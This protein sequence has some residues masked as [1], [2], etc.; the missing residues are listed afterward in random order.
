VPAFLAA[1]ALASICLPAAARVP[2]AS[3]AVPTSAES[4]LLKFAEAIA[5][6]Q[7]GRWK[8]SYELLKATVAS[9]GFAEM[10]EDQQSAG[11]YLLGSVALELEEPKVALEALRNATRWKLAAGDVWYARL[12]AAGESKD[13]ADAASTLTH[14]ARVF[15]EVL[16]DINDRYIFAVLKRASTLDWKAEAQFQLAD[17]LY[18]AHWTPSNAYYSAAHVRVVLAR[19]LIERGNLYKAGDVLKE[20]LGPDEVIEVRTNKVFDPIVQKDLPAFDVLAAAEQELARSRKEADARPRDLEGV[21]TV[22]TQLLGLGRYAEALRFVEAAIARAAPPAGKTPEFDDLG[23]LNWT[24]DYRARALEGLGRHDEAIAVLKRGARRP[25]DGKLNVSQAINLAQYLM[26]LGRPREALDAV[27]DVT[28]S[29]MSGYG[30]LSTQLAR[31]CSYEQLGDKE[32]ASV[33]LEDIMTNQKDGMVV[34]HQALLCAGD[35]PRAAKLL[36]GRLENPAE[37]SGALKELQDYNP[38][39]GQTEMER[40][41]DARLFAVRSRPEVQAAIAKVGR[42]ER[43]PLPSRRF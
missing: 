20:P 1:L 38:D 8:E 14:I 19:G 25:E 13:D 11:Q 43:Q 21:N 31:I 9:K 29:D 12:R 23:P 36:V 39:P 32:K 28:R 40:R 18:D 34:A 4:A 17:A 37:R 30:W 22:A 15:P 10:P 2:A 26:L 7:A 33:A 6:V 41:L 42:I 5:L 27:A 24:Y 3:P 35:E 16:E